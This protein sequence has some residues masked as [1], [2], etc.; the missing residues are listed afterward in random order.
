MAWRPMSDGQVGMSHTFLDAGHESLVV[1]FQVY[2]LGAYYT[3]WDVSL[4]DG[5]DKYF[6][7]HQCHLE[8]THFGRLME[9]TYLGVRL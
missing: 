9:S 3:D 7:Q 4:L 1:V 8:E 6:E 5:V 2:D